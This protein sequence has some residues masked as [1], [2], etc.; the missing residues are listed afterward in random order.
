MRRPWG[1]YAFTLIYASAKSTG[2]KFYPQASRASHPQQRSS[3]S[4]LW[5]THGS[6]AQNDESVT[7]AAF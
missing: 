6:A 7:E 4:V 3:S 1:G 2:A 5:L